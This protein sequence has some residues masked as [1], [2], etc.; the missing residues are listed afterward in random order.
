MVIDGP[1]VDALLKKYNIDPLHDMIVCA[2]GAGGYGNVMGEGR[3]WYTLRYWGVDAA[4]LAVLNGGNNWLAASSMTPADFMTKP[5][6][7]PTFPGTVSVRDLPADNTELQA[8]VQDMLAILPSTD[9][10]V[11][12]DGVFIWDARNEGQYSAGENDGTGAPVANY[13][14]TFQNNGS[15]QG[16]PDGAL[17]LN[18]SNLLIP[19]EGYRYKNKADLQSYLDGNV[20]SNGQ[21]FIDGTYQDVGAGN[22]YQPGDTIYTYCETTFRAMITGIASAVVLGKPT[23]F[24]DGAMVEWHSLSHL[25]DATGNYI[26]PADSPWRT[27]VVSFFRPADAISKVATRTINNPYATSANAIV[28]ADRAYK[29]GTGSSST[30]GG[31]SSGGGLVPANPCGG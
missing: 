1:T 2:Q 10:N 30:S 18:F 6:P 31:S 7:D 17:D 4:H 3:C 8:T 29:R 19:A 26:L 9:T 11:L 16:H 15:S 25:Q 5:S 24:Y 23:R 28:D 13:M 20:D 22:A 27:D 14:T 12:N 21:G